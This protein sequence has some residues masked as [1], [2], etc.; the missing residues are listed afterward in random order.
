MQFITIGVC[1][2][3]RRGTLVD[4][5]CGF[6]DDML[7][8][9]PAPRPMTVSR[10]IDLLLAE[11]VAEDIAAPLSARFTLATVC[12]DLCRLANEEIPAAVA[13]AL[14]GPAHALVYRERYQEPA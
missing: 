10:A 8:A 2:C 11:L 14:D 12:A 6:C 13:E 4:G 3:G 7:A 5:R 1:F 9:A